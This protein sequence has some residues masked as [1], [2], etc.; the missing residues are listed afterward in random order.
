MI[1]ADIS[2]PAYLVEQP[3]SDRK[4]LGRNTH[5]GSLNRIPEGGSQPRIRPRSRGCWSK[6]TESPLPI[7]SQCNRLGS[8]AFDHAAGFCSR[9]LAVANHLLAVDENLGDTSRQLARFF[10]GGVILDGGGV[11]NDNVCKVS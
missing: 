3:R 2:T 9:V 5:Q 8:V 6:E 1:G 7:G 10:K 4:V 11:E